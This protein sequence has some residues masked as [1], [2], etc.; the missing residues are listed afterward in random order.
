[1][2]SMLG[3]KNEKYLHLGCFP[4][5]ADDLLSCLPARLTAG[6]ILAAGLF[7]GSFRQGLKVLRADYN[8]HDSPNSAW[9]EAAA[10]GVL[11]LR[12]GGPDSYDGAIIERPLINA[13]GSEPLSGDISKGLALFRDSSL[14]A[15]ILF[16][17]A[18]YWLRTWEAWPF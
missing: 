7:R 13:G 15:F 5:R 3:Y 2:D 12:F 8:K 17:P 4:A 6:F 11:G 18:V 10:A 14:L 1:M 16:L 9:P